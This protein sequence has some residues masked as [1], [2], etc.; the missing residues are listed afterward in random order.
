MTQIGYRRMLTLIGG[1]ALTGSASLDCSVVN[2]H[3]SFKPC[4]QQ[5]VSW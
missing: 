1:L 2:E 5:S 3:D 4:C